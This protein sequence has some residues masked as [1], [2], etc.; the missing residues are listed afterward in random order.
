LTFQDIIRQEIEQSRNL[1]PRHKI[2]K[3]EPEPP[4]AGRKGKE[5]AIYKDG[6]FHITNAKGQTI[7]VLP[8]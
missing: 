3:T 5:T 6:M 8:S 2:E 7:S 1:K 4:T